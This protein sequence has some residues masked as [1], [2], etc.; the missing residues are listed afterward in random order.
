M[1][2]SLLIEGLSSDDYFS[3]LKEVRDQISSLQKLIDR[4]EA[5]D[6]LLTRSQT[7]EFLQID[8]STLWNWTNKGKVTAYGIANRRY[9]RRSELLE[10]LI[11]L[12]K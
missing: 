10:S 2:K 4:K 9:Y 11:P 12:R 5:N 3:H 1:Q 6:E 7:C 8:S